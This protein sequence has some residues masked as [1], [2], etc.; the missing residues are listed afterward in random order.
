ME[1][2]CENRDYACVVDPLFPDE[3][4]CKCRDGTVKISADGKCEGMLL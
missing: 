2:M 3:P 1:Y 4:E